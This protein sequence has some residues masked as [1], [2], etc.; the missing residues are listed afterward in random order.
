MA[1]KR[2]HAHSILYS[3]SCEGIPLKCC[4]EVKR[5]G[6]TLG[7]HLSLSPFVI[8]TIS[9]AHYYLKLVQ[10]MSQFLP[11]DSLITV[12]NAIINGKLY[13]CNSLFVGAP[14]TSFASYDW[15]KTE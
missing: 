6:C 10:K 12:A 1:Q 14:K 3:F 11:T 7:A 9:A 15:Y 2:S 5:L 8:S 4:N 13:Y